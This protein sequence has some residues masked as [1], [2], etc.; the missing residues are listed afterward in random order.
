MPTKK[1]SNAGRP[2]KVDFSKPIL[3][4]PVVQ[5]LIE[6]FKLDC[7]VDEACAYA[8]ISKT[9]YYEY[10]DKNPEF[11]EEIDAAREYLILLSR[12]TVASSIKKGDTTDAK[13][14]LERK[15]KGEFSLRHEMT[16]KDG[17]SL[18]VPLTL[19]PNDKKD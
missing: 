7:T 17:D 5:K 16:G 2:P 8:K 12:Q 11:A 18:V 15:R 4:S 14:Y 9:T 1:K 19:L 6:A 13:W 3:E 10:L